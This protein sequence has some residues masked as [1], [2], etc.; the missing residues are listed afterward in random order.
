MQFKISGISPKKSVILI[1]SDLQQAGKSGL[2]S[3]AELR[4]VRLEAQKDQKIIS[5]NQY[6]RFV[7]LCVLPE[8]QKIPVSEGLRRMGCTFRELLHKGKADSVLITNRSA[9]THAA[10]WL[11]EGIALASYQFIKYF[12]DARKRAGSLKQLEF[13]KT[14]ITL[15]ELNQLSVITEAVGIARDLVNEPLNTLGAV[16]LS[17]QITALG[18]TAG[19]RTTVLN[20]ARITSEKMGGIL[21]VNRGSIDPPSFSVMEYK[22]AKVLNRQPIVLVGKGIVY[23]TGGLS[24]K[25]TPNS[26]D[27]MKSD[28]SGAALVSA[29]LYAVAKLKL[30][31]HVIGLVPATDNRPGENAYVP[32]DVIRM[33]DGTTVEVL[34]TDAEGRLVLADALHWAKR[35]KP[36]LVIDFATLTGAAAAITGSESMIYMGTA[37][38]TVKKNF[39]RCGQ[40]QY[41]RMV[42]LPLWTEYGEMI[43]S[44]IADLKN[45]GG[46]YGGAITAGKFL[47][48][49]TAYPWLHFDIAGV[50]FATARKH[51]HCTGGT[52][53]GLRM[54]LDYLMHYGK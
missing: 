22:A 10:Y 1:V 13:D 11:A 38:E 34:N 51:Y 37:T 47:E 28:M 33:Y 12:S 44:D 6:T 52:A 35:Y 9:E 39:E 20:K 25:P 17:K 49:F 2:L 36:E 21:A 48:H 15:K 54:L 29:A 8:A 7:H 31:L 18:K 27:R 30:P 42:E 40:Q 41:E 43:K 3:E 32:G 5:I 14:S 23:D 50:S 53:F 19:F 16:A 45:V 46:P 24:L 26:M 4:F